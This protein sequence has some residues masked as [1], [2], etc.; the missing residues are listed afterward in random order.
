MVKSE[1]TESLSQIDGVVFVGGTSVLPVQDWVCLYGALG[2]LDSISFRLEHVPICGVTHQPRIMSQNVDR[3]F[4]FKWRAHYGLSLQIHALI[5]HVEQV[6][7][8]LAWQDGTPFDRV[9]ILVGQIYRVTPNHV[10]ILTQ[11]TYASPV[12]RN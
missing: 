11:L 1:H 10:Q 3:V 4:F 9:D 12:A 7:V 8:G 5:I 6:E 2:A